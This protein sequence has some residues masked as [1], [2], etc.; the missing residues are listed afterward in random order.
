MSIRVRLLLVWA[1]AKYGR[2]REYFIKYLRM[3]TI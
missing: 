2:Y 1:R 3:W